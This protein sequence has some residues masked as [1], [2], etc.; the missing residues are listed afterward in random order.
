MSVAHA[1]GS[2]CGLPAKERGATQGAVSRQVAML[3]Q[4]LDVLLFTRL[5]AKSAVQASA[6]GKLKPITPDEDDPGALPAGKG[7]WA[8]LG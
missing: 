5:N 1:W 2:A 6:L 7:L 8:G 3:E 4:D